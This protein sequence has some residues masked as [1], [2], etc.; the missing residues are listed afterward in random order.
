MRIDIDE[1][2]AAEQFWEGMR[3]VAASAARHQDRDLY[4]SLVKI[5]RAALAQGAQLVPSCGLFL[6]CP[7]C[8]SVPGERCI[9]VPG[10][11]LGNTTLHPQRVQLA[12]RALRGEV[13]LPSSLA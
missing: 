1:P 12:E 6:P 13:P 4:R 8:D 11:P 2:R 10:H 3:E 9:N 7:V 5:G